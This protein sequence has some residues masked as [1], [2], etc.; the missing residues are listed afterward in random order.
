VLEDKLLIWNLRRGSRDALC[1]IYEKYRD[2]LL[3]IA[4]GLLKE[5]SEAEDAVHDVF[6]VF[7]DSSKNFTLK[8]SLKGYL[9]ICVANRARNII[10]TKSRKPT[11]S[12]DKIEPIVSDLKRPDQWI[13]YNE[14][15]QQICDAMEQLPYEQREVVVLHTQGNMKFKDIAKLQETPIKTALSRYRYGIDKL[16]S[17]LISEVPK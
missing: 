8:G 9:I 10:R 1:R 16:R 7:V 6:T 2:D 11:V 14:Q 4:A 3:R 17:L 13:I 15:F 5:Q 12:I